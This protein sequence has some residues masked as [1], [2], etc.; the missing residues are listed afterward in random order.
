M[1]IAEV[2][3]YIYRYLRKLAEEKYGQAI[4]KCVISWPARSNQDQREGMKR[5]ARMAGL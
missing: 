1:K 5:A 4:E 3:S 2:M